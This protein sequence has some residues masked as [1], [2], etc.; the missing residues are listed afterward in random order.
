[1]QERSL[2]NSME[3][4]MKKTAAAFA[5]LMA[6]GSFAFAQTPGTNPPAQTPP[7]KQGAAVPDRTQTTPN[8]SARSNENP[9]ANKKGDGPGGTNAT[10]AGEK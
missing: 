2:G 5:I 3:R 6:S 10:G 9:A 1:V 4:V 8:P 7:D